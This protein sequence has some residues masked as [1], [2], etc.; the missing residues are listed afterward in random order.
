M[1]TYRI[2]WRDGSGCYRTVIQAA[3][4]SDACARLRRRV[5]DISVVSVVRRSGVESVR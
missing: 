5:S 3:S 2:I 1:N 4:I